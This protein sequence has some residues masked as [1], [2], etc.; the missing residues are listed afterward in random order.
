[1][2]YILVRVLEHRHEVKTLDF[3]EWSRICFTEQQVKAKNNILLKT[4]FRYFG[5]SNQSQYL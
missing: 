5:A 1:M 4:E 2:H 3:A